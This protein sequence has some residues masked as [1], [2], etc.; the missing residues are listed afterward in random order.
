MSS[1]KALDVGA[2]EAR[3]AA[4]QLE[5]VLV[6]GVVAAGDHHPAVGRRARAP[7]RRARA[8][9]RRRRRRRRTPALDEARERARRRG[10]AREAAVP[11]DGDA[12]AVRRPRPSIVAKP[13]PMPAA[14]SSVR[15]RSA[16]PR[17]S[18][19]RKIWAGTFMAS[20]S[21]AP[22]RLWTEYFRRGPS[23]ARR[24]ADNCSCQ[25]ETEQRRDATEIGGK[26]MGARCSV[27]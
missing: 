4:H 9:G 23:S 8:S 5:A 21:R 12:N 7:R 3:L 26:T 1:A 17:M 13:R 14:T 11:A 27:L 25:F 16:T 19:S 6:A 24:E 22:R 15:S 2:E 18:Y 10:V 20:R